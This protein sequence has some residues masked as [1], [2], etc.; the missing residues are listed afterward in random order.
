MTVTTSTIIWNTSLNFPFNIFKY[1]KKRNQKEGEQSMSM[2]N[3]GISINLLLD[4]YF[5]T[6]GKTSLAAQF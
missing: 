4:N 6:S 5:F 1:K 2:F 3:N